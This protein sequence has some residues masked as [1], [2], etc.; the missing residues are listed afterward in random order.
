ME[1]FHGVHTL[2]GVTIICQKN[3]LRMQK[4]NK[5]RTDNGRAQLVIGFFLKCQYF[6]LS[7]RDFYIDPSLPQDLADPPLLAVENV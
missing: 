4:I 1:Y 3:S 2:L 7:L 5:N 6:S